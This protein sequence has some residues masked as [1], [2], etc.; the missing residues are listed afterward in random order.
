MYRE[1]TAI[2]QNCLCGGGGREGWAGYASAT[3]FEGWRV[4][5]SRRRARAGRGNAGALRELPFR[6]WRPIRSVTHRSAYSVTYMVM[7]ETSS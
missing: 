1:L 4:R 6:R 2:W 5:A 7:G 3:G